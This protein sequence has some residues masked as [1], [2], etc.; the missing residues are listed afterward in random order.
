MLKKMPLKVKPLQDNLNILNNNLNK[1]QSIKSKID[2]ITKPFLQKN[3]SLNKKLKFQNIK[4][5]EK[6]RNTKKKILNRKLGFFKE[7]LHKNI[8]SQRRKSKDK[9]KIRKPFLKKETT[10]TAFKGKKDVNFS[11]EKETQKT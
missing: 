11:K 3:I 9:S 10:I 4:N 8:K 5:L 1:G 6:R 2:Q 7:T